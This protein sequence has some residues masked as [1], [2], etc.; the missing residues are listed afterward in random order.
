M[1]F[2]YGNLIREEIKRVV[3]RSGDLCVA[4]AYW[5]EGGAKHTGIADRSDPEN[6]RVICD[7][8]SGVCNPSEIRWLKCHG[9]RV[10]K[11]SGLH[12]KVWVSGSYVVIGS[13]NASTNGLGDESAHNMNVEAALAARDSIVARD[14]HK[15]FNW[16][17]C[18]DASDIDKGDLREAERRWKQRRRLPRH[19]VKD[20][21]PNAPNEIEPRFLKKTLVAHVVATAQE[22]WQSN[23]ASDITDISVGRSSQ[24]STWW[25]AYKDYLGHDPVVAQKRKGDIHRQ[26]GRRIR[27][28]IGA[29]KA[30]RTEPANNRVLGTY[31]PLFKRPPKA[32]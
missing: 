19:T 1:R 9:V 12:A 30:K 13:A 29:D 28:A 16:H 31:T 20:P 23:P 27:A 14:L 18:H 22:L 3:G 25:N 17:W 24:D 6:I 7:L 32:P 2:L 15:W 4:V 21:R 11:L 10:K 5:G 8:L 26:F